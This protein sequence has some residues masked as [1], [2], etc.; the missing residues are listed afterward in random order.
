[1]TGTSKRHAPSHIQP[2]ARIAALTVA[3]H[4]GKGRRLMEAALTVLDE[5]AL[6]P[7]CS[8]QA[9]CKLPSPSGRHEAAADA[10]PDGGPCAWTLEPGP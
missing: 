3:D 5:Q 7:L 1:M 4:Q 10:W 9:C 6:R 2:K 8:S